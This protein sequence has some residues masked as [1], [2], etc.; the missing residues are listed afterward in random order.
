M[1]VTRTYPGVYIEE[2]P[3]GVRTIVG[4]ATSVTAF[5][6][7]AR[8]GP[9]D[10]ATTIHSFGEFERVFGGLWE[11]SR[12]GHA[13]Y[14][15]FLNGGADAVIVRVDNGGMTATLTFGAST[16]AD[17]VLESASPGSWAG[18][19][20]GRV[21]LDTADPS[22]ADLFNL[23]IRDL[24]TGA[25]ETFR[26]VSVSSTDPRSVE[27]VLKEESELVTFQSGGGELT[28]TPAPDT[29]ATDFEDG[30]SGASSNA[31]VAAFSSST[32]Q[33]GSPLQNS[34]V[35]GSAGPPKTGLSALD[36][37]DIIN[38][39]CIPPYDATTGAVGALTDAL[40][41][42][43]SRR[44]VLLVDPAPG[45]TDKDDPIDATDGI[46]GSSFG[47]ARD[48][49]AAIYF[50]RVIG[51]DPLQEG[52]PET[53]PPCGAVAGVIA[54]T[55]ATRGVWKAPAGTGATLLGVAD[56]EV[57]LT[58]PEN[59]AL[60]KEGINC[61]RTFPGTGRVVWGARTMRGA[62][63]LADEWK[64]LPVR[65]LALFIEESLYRGTQWVVF[66]PNDEPLWAQIRLSVGSFMHDLFRQGAFQ[67]S[68]AQDA[69]FVKCDGETTTQ[70]DI[71]QG[72]VNILVGFA[73]LKPA[74]FVVIRIRQMAGQIET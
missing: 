46:D 63:R 58:D 1:P 30:P 31:V 68:K 54:R 6:G 8:R 67:G 7:R 25:E 11:E 35:I 72:I 59:G 37:A 24:S 62:D 43:R 65:R 5:V 20:R 33:D 64:Y 29:G 18:A 19:L 13:I 36:A 27:R 70:S 57:R 56:L 14:H 55:D 41:Y 26:N 71:N 52:R 45:W 48:S 23:R 44:A 60:N 10:E 2:V 73:P 50:P 17:L 28:A 47:L 40:A 42:A 51:P 39:L 69:Y 34:D 9:V 4:V 74:E 3:S 12:L 15:Y 21:D 38:L 49:H 53:F 16:G 61:L 22:N 32:G 66:E